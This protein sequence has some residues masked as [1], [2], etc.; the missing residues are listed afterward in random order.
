MLG[1]LLA[2]SS[3]P[4]LVVV[5]VF[6]QF[7]YDY[8]TRFYPFFGRG[9]FKRLI[10]G[11]TS[12]TN[13]HHTHVPTF[14]APGHATISTGTTPRHHGIVA[15]LW[16]DPKTLKRVYAVSDPSVKAVGGKYRYGES[17][18]NLLTNTVGDELRMRTGFK[19]KVIS[20]SLK[21]RA[22]ILMGGHL[23][24]LALWFSDEDGNF[25][26]STYYTKEVPPWLKE[27]NSKRFADKYFHRKWEKI[28]PKAAY[29]TSLKGSFPH[30]IGEK[31]EKPD[32]KYYRDLK[33]SP[34]GNDLLL[35]LAKAAIRGEGLGKDT[36]PDIL[37]VSFSS[38]DYV[39]HIYGPYSEEVADITLR[40]D[41]I[42]ANLL[43]F[44]DKEVGKGNYVLV[45][46]SDHGVAPVPG[47]IEGLPSERVSTDTLRRIIK[48]VLTRRY[49]KGDWV[50][51][52]SFPWIYLNDTLLARKGNPA[53]ARRIVKDAL[54]KVKGIM[55]VFTREE[56]ERG[57]FPDWDRTAILVY[58]GFNPQRSGDLAVIP[59]AFYLIGSYYTGTN[60]GTP[61][62]YDTHVPLV[63]Y[64]AGIPRGKEVSHFCST[65][66]IAPT[67]SSMLRIEQ[68]ASGVGEVLPTR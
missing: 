58:N 23:A 31:S 15:N 67:I 49:G 25:V 9:G 18:R 6:E 33:A 30:V 29:S 36:V 44:L 62:T 20:L 59:R 39:G 60:H 35:R 66:S 51:H 57:G 52:V 38:N 5:V 64:G 28:G 13:C 2:T 56:L 43:K 17:P 1:F 34:F 4:G 48:G 10:Q 27:F 68:P 55:R 22:A 61:Y 7:R 14:T 11:G 21:D 40:S 63:F 65:T 45:L 24:N 46:T 53:E 12:F 41:R 16:Y 19:G 3:S 54:L 37:F 42:V 50:L 32:R 26:T 47:R 8:I